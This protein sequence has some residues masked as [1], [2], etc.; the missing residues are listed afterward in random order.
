MWAGCQHGYIHQ[1]DP[2]G[3]VVRTLH[4]PEL[5]NSTI[6]CMVRT[7]DGDALMGLHSG[8]IVVYSKMLHRFVPFVSSPVPVSPIESMYAD[9]RDRCW[10]GTLN[11][12]AE[13]D[14]RKGCF[15]AV[16]RPLPGSD[17]RCSGITAY[18]DSLL[19][20]G[21][22]NNGLYFFN[23]HTKVFSKIAINEEQPNTSVHAVGTDTTGKIWF[24]TDFAICNYDP[25]TN[26]CFVH[27]PEKGLLNTSFSSCLFLQSGAGRWITWTSAEIVGFLP[28]QISSLQQKT[29]LVTITG[30]RVFG[31]PLFID[32]LVTQQKPV[33]L[34]YKENF[35]GIEFSNLQ[36]SGIERTKYYY[37]LEGVDADWVYGGTRGSA[38]YTNLSPGDYAFRVRTE[39]PG[40]DKE[41]AALSIHIAAPYW[42]T[43]WFRLLVIVAVILVILLLVR[44]YNRGLRQEAS[45]KQQVAETEMMAL[46]AQMNPHFIFNCINSI[47]ALIQ[48]ND[49]YQATVYLNKFA[50]LIRNILDSSKQ[51]TISLSRDLETLQLY[52]DLERFRNED[53]FTAEIRVD[54]QLLEEDCRVPPLIVQPYVENAILHGLR[55]LQGSFG[56]LT[57]EVSKNEEYLVYRIEDNG[58]GRGAVPNRTQ[59][60]SY[61]M[62]MSRDRVN[63]FNREHNIPVIITDLEENGQPAGTRVQVSLKMN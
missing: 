30:F 18:H 54:E 60:R 22:E 19:I 8:K 17:V 11:G 59:H 23:R 10:A 16:Y 29:S 2:H 40:A 25:V 57:I 56:R 3:L 45:M 26:K 63:L 61:G 4:P 27:Q 47:D 50:R 15:V 49:K 35:I 24:S 38:S 1:I 44:W 28:A 46:R 21:T 52:I 6:K 36:Y 20:V 14:I 53:R 48:C 5:E 58:V 62:E 33:R 34:S 31:N 13:Y 51:P 37:R 32:T 43:P 12:L 42:A 55:N 9:D 39:N 7:K 41:M